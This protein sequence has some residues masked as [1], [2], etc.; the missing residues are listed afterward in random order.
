MISLD[1]RC[2]FPVEICQGKKIV[3]REMRMLELCLDGQVGSP[4]SV[5][6]TSCGCLLKNIR[7]VCEGVG[8][9]NVE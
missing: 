3:R 2:C 6:A 8:D 7:M 5:V 1:G 4:T 9:E